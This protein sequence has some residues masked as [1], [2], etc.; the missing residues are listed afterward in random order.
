MIIDNKIEKTFSGPLIFMGLT[1]MI[2]AGILIFTHHYIFAGISFI[3]GCFVLF[4]FSGIDIDTEKRIIRPYYMI[5][6]LIKKG[7]WESLER[8]RGLTLVPMKK[9]SSVYSRSNRMNSIIKNEFRVYLVNRAKKPAYPL[10]ICKSREDAQTSMDEFAI[11]L[12]LP[13]YSVKKRL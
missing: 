12:K 3:I 10:K 9:V 11:W 8:F 5:F 7:K 4:T 1:F 13:V 2:I 6:G